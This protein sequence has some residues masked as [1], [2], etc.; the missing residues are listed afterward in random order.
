M[1]ESPLLKKGIGKKTGVRIYLRVHVMPKLNK[2]LRGRAWQWIAPI[3]AAGI[4]I[5]AAFYF[6][7]P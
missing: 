2:P 6:L 5:V 3:A 7:A 1:N 4:L